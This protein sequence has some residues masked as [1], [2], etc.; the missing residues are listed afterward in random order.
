MSKKIRVLMITGSWP[1]VRCGVGDYASKLV[2]YLSK[3]LDVHIVTSLGADHN[4]RV[5]NDIKKWNLFN[6]PRVRRHIID[7]QPDIIHMQYP[8]VM[9]RRNLFPNLLPRLI[10]RKFPKIPFVLTIHEYHDASLLGKKRIELTL[11]GPDILIFTN[12]NDASD[13]ESFLKQDQN[14]VI[15]I[16]SNIEVAKI[17]EDKRVSLLDSYGLR[18][19]KYWLYIGFVD[20][21]KGLGNLLD[22]IRMDQN[23]LPLVI[24]TE[25][26]ETNAYHKEIRA[27]IDKSSASVIWTNYVSSEDLSILLGAAYAVV[28]PFDKPAT[29]R[30]GSVIAALEHGKAIITTGDL[31]NS[32]FSN[33][34]KLI[35]DNSLESISGAMRSLVQDPKE[36]RR[37]ESAAKIMVKKYSW[38]EIA[39][40]HEEV[41]IER[42]RS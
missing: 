38:P 34:A 3:K 35:P 20:P 30:R 33:S 14:R 1:P 32:V 37:L 28:L 36:K 25:Y 4:E 13:L 31:Q 40:A 26:D 22:A 18:N 16:G 42:S 41:Y 21:S 5:Y 11:K 23:K 2:S 9:Y 39:R 6:W 8:S 15:P 29:N 19:G 7:L 27:R 10:K 17:S 12:D 24:A